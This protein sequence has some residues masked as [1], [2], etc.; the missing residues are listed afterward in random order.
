MK[1]QTKASLRQEPYRPDCPLC[2]AGLV[3]AVAVE[4]GRRGAVAGRGGQPF[5][6]VPG[7]V[8]AAEDALQLRE[9]SLARL[10][11]VAIDRPRAA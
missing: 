10:E 4:Q 1:A 7:R 3:R 6:R 5:G 11:V 2:T 8:V 9:T